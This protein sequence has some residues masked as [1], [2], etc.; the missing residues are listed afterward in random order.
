M[1]LILSVGVSSG[2]AGS[3]LGSIRSVTQADSGTTGANEPGLSGGLRS[4]ANDTQYSTA[5]AHF[6][7][8]LTVDLR[9]VTRLH[10]VSATKCVLAV[11]WGKPPELAAI[12]WPSQ[13]LQWATPLPPS[14]EIY[15]WD[16]RGSVLVYDIKEQ[17]FLMFDR[18]TGVVRDSIRAP[19]GFK[20][21]Q[22]AVVAQYPEHCLG[23]LA[24]D[25]YA[26]LDD[27][28]RLT[29]EVSL[30]RLPSRLTFMP[31]AVARPDPASTRRVIVYQSGLVLLDL[32]RP[33]SA[34]MIDTSMKQVFGQ[35][36]FDPV[37]NP[38]N[39]LSKFTL[40]DPESPESM[41][42]ISFPTFSIGAV[43]WREPFLFLFG[44]PFSGPGLSLR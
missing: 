28:L 44:G 16:F 35:K 38:I 32:A 26:E 24:N 27:S 34:T 43:A 19:N 9:E 31:K 18:V 10:W 41:G 15:S 12:S 23:V 40:I 20:P 25:I 4:A 30:E 2:T 29:L 1:V 13:T 36:P 14:Y 11:S 17:S 33:D 39:P 6:R 7:Y 21:G 22:F 3:I 5:R 37:P 42:T 8:F